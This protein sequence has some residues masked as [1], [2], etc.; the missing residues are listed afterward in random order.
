MAG[1]RAALGPQLLGTVMMEVRDMASGLSTACMAELSP[2]ERR[3]FPLVAEG[4]T[5]KEIAV[6]P[7]ALR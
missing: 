6:A 5:N 3:L 1:G 7:V 2:Q 4:K